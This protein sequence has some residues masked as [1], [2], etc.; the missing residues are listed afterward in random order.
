MN[1]LVDL[2]YKVIHN[3]TKVDQYITGNNSYS[4][5]KSS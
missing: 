1:D 2:N 4:E 5:I 3:L